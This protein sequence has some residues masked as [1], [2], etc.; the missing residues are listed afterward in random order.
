LATV[1]PAGLRPIA[2][3]LPRF[4]FRRYHDARAGCFI[5]RFPVDEVIAKRA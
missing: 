2:S 5:L 1:Q 3:Y 4:G